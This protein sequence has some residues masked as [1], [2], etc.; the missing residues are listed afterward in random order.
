WATVSTEHDP[1]AES[2]LCAAEPPLPGQQCPGRPADPASWTATGGLAWR[3]WSAALGL[4]AALPARAGRAGRTLRAEN[5]DPGRS[6]RPFQPAAGRDPVQRA[7]PQR[8]A[9]A[10][11]GWRRTPADPVCRLSAVP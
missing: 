4:A 1:V 11:A 3:T 2:G 7:L 6:C 8:T 5:P 10:P 9:G